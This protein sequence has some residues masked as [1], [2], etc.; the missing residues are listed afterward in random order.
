MTTS[1]FSNGAEALLEF[2]RIQGTEFM[3]CSPIGIW[4]PLWEALAKR[5]ERG[6][7]DS[8]R[9]LNCRHEMLAVGLASGFYKAT[10]RPQ[11]VLLPTGLG[12]LH[13]SMAIRSA[14]Q[15]RIP[16]IILSP[17]TVTYGTEPAL[18]PGMEWPSLLVDLAGPA[19]DAEVCVKWAKEVKTAHDLIA[20]LRRA[21]YFAE[22]VPRGPTLLGVPFEILMS[23]VAPP[24][25]P[26]LEAH[27]VVAATEQL[28]QVAE[29]L[30]QSQNP[31]I[32]TEHAAR[33]PTEVNTLVKL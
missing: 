22:M 32:I 33:T 7:P 15:E 31:V 6:E 17:D 12:V 13:G 1:D 24:Q 14:L 30:T 3:F 20:D 10:G 18:D 28:R 16:M 29:L 25:Q 23:P 4:A 27:P 19:R 8:P 11:V 9:Y 21:C 2:L 26:K 5:D